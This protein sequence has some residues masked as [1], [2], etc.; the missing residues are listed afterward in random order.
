VVAGF[1]GGGWD[2]KSVKTPS[3]EY[4]S[5]PSTVKNVLVMGQR[6]R[7]RNPWCKVAFDGQVIVRVEDYKNIDFL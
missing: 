4:T 2:G 7:I 1:E 5:M 3:P 6:I